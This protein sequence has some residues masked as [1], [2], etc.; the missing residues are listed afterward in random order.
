MIDIS[1]WRARIGLWYCRKNSL[2]ETSTDTTPVLS[3]EGFPRNRVGSHNVMSS[4]VL[5]LLLLILSGDIELNPGPKTGIYKH[6]LESCMNISLFTS[7][8]LTST[9]ALRLLVKNGFIVED[10]WTK[11]TSLLG[12][13]LKERKRLE[14]MA[15]SNQ[16]YH[17]ALEQ[18][19]QWWITNSTD[20]SWEKLVS[21][22]ESCGDMNVQVANMMKRQVDTKD[23]G[24]GSIYPS[25]I[26]IIFV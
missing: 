7:T 22:V 23:E 17:F 19:L 14:T 2:W 20:P 5:F 10:K 9:N 18:S 15:S 25:I 6:Y 12:V 16:D 21:A 3:G 11:L 24:I 26:L 1:Q 8:E 4:L 13:S